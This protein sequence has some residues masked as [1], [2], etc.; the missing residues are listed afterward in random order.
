ML[1]YYHPESDSL[2]MEQY[3]DID[4]LHVEPNQCVEVTDDAEMVSRYNRENP[5]YESHLFHGFKNCDCQHDRCT[6]CDG[7]LA[8][9]KTCQSG[10]CEVTT[11]CP[12]APMTEEQSA[13]VCAGRLDYWSGVWL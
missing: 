9:C 10:E 11:N 8:Y 12:G 6:I 3:R 13:E 5:G 4:W 1:L 2:F 7:G